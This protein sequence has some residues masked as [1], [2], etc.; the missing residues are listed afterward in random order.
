MTAN[1]RVRLQ[2]LRAARGDLADCDWRTR[3]AGRQKSLRS[4]GGARAIARE[5]SSASTAEPPI[6]LKLRLLVIKVFPF[7]MASLQA[8][9]SFPLTNWTRHDGWC[10]FSV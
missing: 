4:P 1:F 3:I 10:R 2:I 8:G 9:D 6:R 7:T 5:I